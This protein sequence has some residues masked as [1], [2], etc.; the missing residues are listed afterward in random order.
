MSSLVGPP[1]S[2][3]SPPP[4]QQS[5]QQTGGGNQSAQQQPQPTLTPEQQKQL[6]IG[7]TLAENASKQ[8]L[9][10]S[11]PEGPVYAEYGKQVP[12]GQFEKDYASFIQKEQAQGASKVSGQPEFR[13][14]DVDESVADQVKYVQAEG[15]RLKVLG[16]YLDRGNPQEV[17][18]YNAEVSVYNLNV[19]AV[20]GE[21]VKQ[22]DVFQSYVGRATSASQLVSAF[23]SANLDV[24]PSLSALARSNPNTLVTIE[25]QASTTKNG[26]SGPRY[27]IKYQ[28][29]AEITQQPSSGGEGILGQIEGAAGTGFGYLTE[30]IG[31]AGY[32]LYAL[33][34]LGGSY[35][36]S[37][38]TGKPFTGQART[39]T[40]KPI[41]T[42]TPQQAQQVGTEGLEG[43]IVITLGVVA[44]T[45][46]IGAGI[47]V[48][49]EEVATGGKANAKEVLGAAAVGSIFAGIGYGVSIAVLKGAGAY[50][51]AGGPGADYVESFL[52]SL[53][54]ASVK[55]A[56]ARAAFGAGTNV[57][58]SAPF[59]TDPTQL[60]EA[61]G[62]G[63]GTGALLPGTI[64][65]V[66]EATGLAGAKA[67]VL[68]TSEVVDLGYEG[69][70]GEPPEVFATKPIEKLG[71]KSLEIIGDVTVNPA[72]ANALEEAYVGKGPVE[73][74]HATLKPFYETEGKV[75]LTAKPGEATGFRNEMESLGLYFA[76]S[77]QAD[78]IRI[79]GG[80]I[81]I[82]EGYSGESPKIVFGGRPSV[83][84]IESDITGEFA[85]KA[86]ESPVDTVKRTFTE[87]SGKVGFPVENYFGASSE[88][89]AITPTAF[90]S[91]KTG[92]EY[93]G[94]IV[95]TLGVKQ[96]FYVKEEPEGLVGKVPLLRSL[97]SK[98]T[99]ASLTP[100]RLK[101]VL[102]ADVL[103]GKQGGGGVDLGD[104]AK[105]ISKGGGVLDVSKVSV[106]VS[107]SDLG[108]RLAS[109]EIS[110]FSE[111]QS[112]Y[113][114][115]PISKA[116]SSPSLKEAS[117]SS[118]LASPSASDL[119]VS[120]SVFSLSLYSLPASPPYS[121]P[122]SPPVSPP[123]SPPFILSF[124][125]K[126]VPQEALMQ[127][128]FGVR[129]VRNYL[130]SSSKEINRALKKEGILE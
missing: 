70:T 10:V 14:V 127:D 37:L 92:E 49:F 98:Y 35:V 104:Y 72:S 103:A 48:G 118:E 28:L 102:A 110:S 89:Q 21:V 42:P 123:S 94:S 25:K 27:A 126:R 32:Y 36:G 6:A 111:G 64:G 119:S 57:A 113:Y 43:A 3:S 50:I 129:F 68:S 22:Q 85:P 17:G 71:G 54:G 84:A 61:A 76:P 23:Q 26:S 39:V 77:D 116:V 105:S 38:I 67:E 88:R 44:P 107:A 4:V 106:P 7:A 101:P 20:Q 46:L 75:L 15:G 65:T 109:E 74:A 62:I 45:T 2:S 80:Y 9:V 66:K 12:K 121:S 73:L 108:S 60:A 83:L 115:E 8:F 69:K 24:S 1:P 96:N 59:T 40:G 56:A 16:K 95:E 30:G 87:G 93:P 52:K 91:L 82:G 5:Q 53:S 41:Q 100:G 29:P 86:G 58:L 55:A 125:R 97:L 114:S 79:Y 81:G 130:A 19:K 18:L 128:F 34:N 90:E 51:E 120:P 63:A 99:F 13:P 117:V 31:Y 78:V 112:E 47:S 11:A 122:S 124:P 33:P